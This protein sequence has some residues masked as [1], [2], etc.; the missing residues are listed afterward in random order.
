MRSIVIF[1]LCLVWGFFPVFAQEAGMFRTGFE[2]GYCGP[3]HGEIGLLQTIEMKLSEP[4]IVF[5]EKG[6]TMTIFPFL[7]N[8]AANT[9]KVIKKV[10][11]KVTYNIARGGSDDPSYQSDIKQTLRQLGQLLRQA[12]AKDG[13]VQFNVSNLPAGIYYLHIYDGIS[14]T[15]EIQQIMIE[16]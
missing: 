15:P 16:R 6:I 9:I 12:V 13:T 8:P 3:P 5:G 2:I 10:T 4:Y 14:S 7:Y 11:F 1:T